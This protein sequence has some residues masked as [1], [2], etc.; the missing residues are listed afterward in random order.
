LPNWISNRLVAKGEPT[1]IREFLNAVKSDEQPFDFRRI[2]PMPELIRHA[3]RVYNPTGIIEEWYVID[4]ISNCRRFT[5][6]EEKQ[7][8][9]LG[10]RCWHDWAIANW[11]TKWNACDVELDESTADLGYVVITFDTAW[12]PPWPVPRRPSEMFLELAFCC[13]WADQEEMF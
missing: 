9:A 12:S 13:G 4:N 10:H 7:L 3:A 2:T 6:E 8:D 11:G 1:A 5:P